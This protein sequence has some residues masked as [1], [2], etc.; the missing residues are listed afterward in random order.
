MK[1]LEKQMDLFNLN[2][3]EYA[4]AHCISADV[5]ATK[6]MG[7]GIAK[8]FRKKYPAM[9][10]IIS[11]K[12]RIGKAIRYEENGNVV[13]NIVSKEKV[14]QKINLSISKDSY[15]GNLKNALYEIKSQML[16][17]GEKKLAMPKIGCGLDRGKWEEVREIIK[18]V[19]NDTEFEV[20]ICY[21]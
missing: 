2:N 17:N 10:G 1:Y 15:Y 5:T 7:A 19:F 12:L 21:L 18:E 14:Y 16:E 8:I 4:F 3:N 11:P 13:Y 6:A 9:A 20:V